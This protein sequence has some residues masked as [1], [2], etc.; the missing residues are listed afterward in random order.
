MVKSG[1]FLQDVDNPV[2][3]RR[4]PVVV[5]FRGDRAVHREIGRFG[6]P[7][8]AVPLHLLADIPDRVVAAA[9]ARER[10][11]AIAT[12]ACDRF[13]LGAGQ[14]AFA[15]EALHALVGRDAGFGGLDPSYKP[16]GAKGDSRSH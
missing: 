16:R 15:P 8:L 13:R 11:G 5:E 14:P 10:L 9:V 7:G 6:V 12:R 3:Q 1:F 4:H 2:I